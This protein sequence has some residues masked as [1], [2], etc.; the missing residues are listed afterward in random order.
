MGGTFPLR[1]FRLWG[2]RKPW[3]GAS[4]GHIFRGTEWGPTG[5][6]W[7]WPEDRDPQKVRGGPGDRVFLFLPARDP[8]FSWLSSEH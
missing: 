4:S 7:D 3:E 5:S 6:G 8:R 2:C 1:Y